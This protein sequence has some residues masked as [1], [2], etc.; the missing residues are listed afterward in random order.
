MGIS[1]DV[2]GTLR[3]NMKHHEPI[4]LIFDARGNGG[5]AIAPT[6]TGDHNAHISDYTALIVETKHETESI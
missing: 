3:A 6:V 4:V 5:G 1:Y 2:T